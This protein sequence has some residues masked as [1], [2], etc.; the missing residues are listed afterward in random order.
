MIERE[1]NIYTISIG[2]QLF[3]T[4]ENYN[5]DEFSTYTNN[6]S[7]LDTISFTSSNTELLL[8]FLENGN[9]IYLSGYNENPAIAITDTTFGI[10]NER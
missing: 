1:D 5:P 3:T 8:E 10:T 4:I 2:I 7:F 6:F 9:S